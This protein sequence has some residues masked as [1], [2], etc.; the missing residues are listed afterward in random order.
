MNDGVYS[1]VPLYYHDL[2]VMCTESIMSMFKV[3][4]IDSLDYLG[5]MQNADIWRK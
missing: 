1:G 4:N 3:Y 5:L 2:S